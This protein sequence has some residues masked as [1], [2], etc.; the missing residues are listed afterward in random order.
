[1]ED[2]HQQKSKFDIKT[3]HLSTEAL[4]KELKSKLNFDEKLSDKIAEILTKYLGSM[5]FLGLNFLFF[6][7]W[8]VWNLDLIPFFE[9]FDPFP[10]G[11]LT[12][13][14][15][16]VA[17]FLSVVVL[18]TQNRQGEISDTRQ[19]IDF[20]IN[21]RGEKEVTKILTML[22]DI[23]KKLGIFKF[24]EELKEMKLETDIEEIKE[25]LEEERD[26]Q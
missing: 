5:W 21:V 19:Q 15:S 3:D 18:I 9:P 25:K 24:D 13:I 4:N 23:Q 7:I 12:M 8:I 6:L 26:A 16:L 10:F 22:E 17:I 2:N 11:L 14:V 20:E 1:M